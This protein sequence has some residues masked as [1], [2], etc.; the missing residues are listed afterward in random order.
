MKKSSYTRSVVRHNPCLA[1]VPR[2]RDE[3]GFFNLRALIGFTLCFAGV[4][5][6]LFAHFSP[7]TDHLGLS[8]VAKA[9]R[10]LQYMPAPGGRPEAEAADLA[11]LERFW[12]DRLTYPTGRFDPGWLRA[13]A[14][15]HARLP[16][17]TKS[18]DLYYHKFYCARSATR[19]YDW[20]FGLF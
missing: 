1:V 4:A 9:S 16:M 19:T 3:G 5:L 15:Q 13:A 10:P 2:L 18:T 14:V 7:V 12:N 17:S 11:R 20:V 6:A 8:G